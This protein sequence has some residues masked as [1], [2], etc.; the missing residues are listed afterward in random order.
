VE[1]DLKK[2]REEPTLLEQYCE[3]SQINF[4]Y[5]AKLGVTHNWERMKKTLRDTLQIVYPASRKNNA[6]QIWEQKGYAHATE[7]EKTHYQ[8]LTQERQNLM[9]KVVNLDKN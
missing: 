2:L 1:Y 3:T 8:T 9:G 4:L 7:Q 5:Q 6:K